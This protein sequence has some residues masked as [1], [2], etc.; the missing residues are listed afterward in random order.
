MARRRKARQRRKA[1]PPSGHQNIFPVFSPDESHW[2]YNAIKFGGRPDENISV[3]D[4]KEVPFIG[5]NPVYTADN[6]LLTSLQNR[7]SD[8]A[9]VIILS[10]V[11][12]LSLSRI[13]MPCSGPRSTPPL[14]RLSSDCALAM[15][16]GLGLLALL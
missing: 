2:A 10:A 16:L 13:G 3:V 6:K 7:A 15:A 14:R 11:A 9:V 12:M 5:F 4:G 1:G 8:P